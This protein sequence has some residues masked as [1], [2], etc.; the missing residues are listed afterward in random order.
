MKDNP[1]FAKSKIGK[2]I[3]VH[4]K[5]AHSQ[6]MNPEVFDRHITSVKILLKTV[7][8]P[9]IFR[10]GTYTKEGDEE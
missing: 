2:V 1:T 3:D 4:I 7:D 6:L 5:A 8:E 10:D 9:Q